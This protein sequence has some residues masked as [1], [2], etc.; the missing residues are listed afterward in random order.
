MILAKGRVAV[1]LCISPLLIWSRY[2]TQSIC[3]RARCWKTF[4]SHHTTAVAIEQDRPLLNPVCSSRS[5]SL[6][7]HHSLQRLTMLR[8]FLGTDSKAILC[9]LSQS[10][11]FPFFGSLII[12][13]F[14]Q[15]ARVWQKIIF[16]TGEFLN[17]QNVIK[18][19]KNSN[20]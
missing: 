20:E 15:F 11:R 10:V 1:L 19:L 13:P 2:E 14:L 9:Q 12:T 17:L 16:Y 4:S 18:K 6:I 3:R 8:T 5:S 7:A